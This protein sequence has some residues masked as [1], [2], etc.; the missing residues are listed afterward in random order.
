[1]MTEHLRQGE[2]SVSAALNGV[3]QVTNEVIGRAS[4]A[5]TSSSAAEDSA[6]QTLNVREST[7]Y[8][9]AFCTYSR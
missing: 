1:M 8:Y 6:M 5:T 4:L 2:S 7:G 3:V 9:N